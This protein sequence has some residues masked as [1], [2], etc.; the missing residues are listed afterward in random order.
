[1]IF[2]LENTLY[3]IPFMIIYEVLLIPY[4]YLRMV[5]NIMKVEDFFPGLGYSSVWL[6][7]GIPYLLGAAVIDVYYFFKVLC[8]Y[9]EDE[10]DDKTEVEDKLQD[11]V[12]IYNEIIDTVRSIVN[13]FKYKKK[14][15][16][17]SNRGVKSL[18]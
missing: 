8:D 6:M 10:F 3:Y 14:K 9:R 4:I 16:Y 17:N 18:K 5:F 13:I 2:W 15:V 1:M 11:K 12:V 7:I